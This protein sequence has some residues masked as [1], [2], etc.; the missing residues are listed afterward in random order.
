[1]L[2][3]IQM[4]GANGLDIAAQ[5]QSQA[6]VRPAII[7]VTAHD[8]HAL[9]AFELEAVDYLTKP[10]RRERLQAAL[11]R[12]MRQRQ[13]TTP[14]GE[15]A[16]LIASERGRAVRIPVSD[17]LFMRAEAKSVQ[18]VTPTRTYVLDESLSELEERVA[19]SERFVRVHRAVLVARESV[20]AF[21]KRVMAQ[22][23]EAPQEAGETWAVHVS[24]VDAWL[25][26]SRRQLPLVKEALTL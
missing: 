6:A 4:P 17:I 20:A 24:A 5:L 25:P 8:Q 18:A 13:V 14:D 26:V 10:V 2:M 3:D 1:V 7:F 22:E 19:G 21:E 11:E 9:R 16:M 23:G 12:V 15:A